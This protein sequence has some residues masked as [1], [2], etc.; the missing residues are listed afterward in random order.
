[1]RRC[2]VPSSGIKVGPTGL[3]RSVCQSHTSVTVKPPAKVKQ[4]KR[5]KLKFFKILDLGYL[6]STENPSKY[7]FPFSPS[8]IPQY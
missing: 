2:S 3:K 6:D 1:M 5:V 4:N 8:F 7:M